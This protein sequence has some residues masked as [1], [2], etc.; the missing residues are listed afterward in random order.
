MPL[1]ALVMIA[2]LSLSFIAVPRWWFSSKRGCRR[3]PYFPHVDMRRLLER[4]NDRARD[5]IGV[6][7]SSPTDVRLNGGTISGIPNAVAD[8]RSRRSRFDHGHANA[9]RR[10][11]LAH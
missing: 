4:K 3:N 6:H 8:L 7:D 1:P 9:Q 5:V 2:V 10:Q 11:L